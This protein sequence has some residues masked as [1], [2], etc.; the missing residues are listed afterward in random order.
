[1]FLW[2][3]QYTKQAKLFRPIISSIC[4]R[5]VKYSHDILDLNSKTNVSEE[6]GIRKYHEIDR[7]FYQ[8]IRAII[9]LQQNL[10]I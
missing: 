1:M 8:K 7:E 10:R 6:E 5:V 4:D 3:P 9:F 2:I